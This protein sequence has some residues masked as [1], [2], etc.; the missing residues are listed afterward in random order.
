MA[1]VSRGLTWCLALGIT[2]SAWGASRPSRR[3]TLPNL[4]LI[5]AEDLAVDELNGLPDRRLVTPNLDELN[6]QGFR[7]TQAYVGSPAGVAARAS[8]LT[9]LSGDQASIRSEIQEPL[10]P[11]DITVAEVVRA[12]GYRTSLVGQWG[13]GWEGTTGL[14]NRQGFLEFLGALDLQHGAYERTQF[15]WRNEFPFTLRPFPQARLDD[16]AASWL[17]RGMTNFVRL[18]EDQPFFLVFAPHLPGGGTLPT[19]PGEPG[20]LA[21]TNATWTAAERSRAV[22]ITRLDTQVGL[23]IADL[24]HRNLSGDTV[25]VLT[26]V[27]AAGASLG[28]NLNRLTG[29]AQGR[30]HGLSEANLRAPLVFWGPGRVR[31]GETNLPV[32]AWDILPTLADIAGTP[33]PA[34]LSGFSLW[35]L[36]SAKN[37]IATNRPPTPLYW[38]SHGAASGQAARLEAWK[39]LRWGPQKTLELYDLRTDPQERTNVVSVHPELAQQFQD[40]FQ[41]RYRKWSPPNPGE[42]NAPGRTGLSV[43]AVPFQQPMRT[44][45]FQ[46]GT[47]PPASP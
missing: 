38:E 7:F 13:L 2:F 47:P 3:S 24:Q 12:V 44:N 35:P 42:T 36:I 4:V 18:N 23:L 16:L 33:L 27:P 10:A 19:L 40:L 30:L 41:A 1:F 39:G 14:P 9:G 5:V 6:R 31:V 34:K 15:L 29:G 22:R 8:L 45:L 20:E 26:S 11:D 43:P 21:Y 17:V 25:V 37:G 46:T 32:A 28:G